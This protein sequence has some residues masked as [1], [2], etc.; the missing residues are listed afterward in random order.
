[1]FGFF[2]KMNYLTDRE[3]VKNQ[4]KIILN[5]HP[6][7]KEAAET[8]LSVAVCSGQCAHLA[9]PCCVEQQANIELSQTHL[10]VALKSGVELQWRL[11]LVKVLE[12]AV[13]LQ[14]IVKT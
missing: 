7:L 1:M 14:T 13:E 3:Y 11:F 5:K 10:S 2:S 6:K 9:V 8:F 12:E 4:D